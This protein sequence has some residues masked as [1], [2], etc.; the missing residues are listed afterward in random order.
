MYQV[1]L[2]EID[3]I[4]PHLNDALRERFEAE[5]TSPQEDLTPGELFDAL[6]SLTDLVR[7]S[8]QHDRVDRLPV[9]ARR[10]LRDHMHNLADQVESGATAQ[11]WHHL[12]LDTQDAVW[13]ELG[14]AAMPTE[15]T[16]KLAALKLESSVTRA[17]SL[18]SELVSLA[19]KAAEIPELHEQAT[20]A[21][22]AIGGHRKQSAQHQEA[23][24][25]AADSAV[26]FQARAKAASEN[27]TDAE[28]DAD[29]RRD[30]IVEFF[31][32]IHE[33]G[34][35]MAKAIESVETAMAALEAKRLG[36][37]SAEAEAVKK[38]AGEFQSFMGA[39]RDEH[40]KEMARVEELL[41]MAVGASLFKAFDQRRRSLS[42]Q[43]W[44]WA[45]LTLLS[46]G[47]SIALVLTLTSD[48]TTVADSVQIAAGFW[49][50][51]SL[52]PLLLLAI[53]FCANQYSRVRRLED[54]YAFK[55]TLSLSLE[56]YRDLVTNMAANA[57]EAVHLGFVVETVRQIYTSPQ[58]DTNVSKRSDHVDKHARA[59]LN[60]ILKAVADLVRKTSS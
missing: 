24:Q 47:G 41:Q 6:G 54:A 38:R 22:A 23:A 21:L 29:A 56:P 2:Q 45:A 31:D 3:R 57:K 30:Q 36:I 14:T 13:R 20:E 12:I 53:G 32:E 11:G 26:Q 25:V 16:A 55:S 50:K 17:A 51:L 28:K 18:E 48:L 40:A 43:A 58:E 7:L 10:R 42:V 37:E 5:I 19:S 49:V 15:D 60:E 1:L 59:G 8:V 34:E 39:S 33:N 35:S 9:R 46:I 4:A 52:T 44:V 27:A